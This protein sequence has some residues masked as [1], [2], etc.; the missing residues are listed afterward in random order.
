MDFFSRHE[1]NTS[2]HCKQHAELSVI[3]QEEEEKADRR[4]L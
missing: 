2:A 4:Q 1:T 3:S